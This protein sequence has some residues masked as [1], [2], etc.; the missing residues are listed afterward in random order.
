MIRCDICLCSR[1]LSVAWLVIIAVESATSFKFR[2]DCRLRRVRWAAGQG[3]GQCAQQQGLGER[4]TI[5]SDPKRDP[6]EAQRGR[7]KRRASLKENRGHTIVP[8]A[9]PDLLEPRDVVGVLRLRAPSR[10]GQPL[11]GRGAGRV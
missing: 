5:L 7:S 10:R 6:A 9:N 1:D 8:Y 4:L 11:R 3:R 2:R